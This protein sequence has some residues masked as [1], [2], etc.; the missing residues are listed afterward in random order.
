MEEHHTVTP[1]LEEEQV[2]HDGR[3]SGIGSSSTNTTKHPA[4]EQRSPRFRYCAPGV[5]SSQ[6][7]QS[8][9]VYWSLA[10]DSH[11]RHPYYVA[12]TEHQ[13]IE[14][15]EECGMRGV[16]VELLLKRFDGDGE[17]R[18][19]DI[20][21]EGEETD[22]SIS[23]DLDWSGKIERVIRVVAWNGDS[24]WHR[25]DGRNFL[26]VFKLDCARFQRILTHDDNKC[27]G[28][29]QEKESHDNLPCVLVTADMY[30]GMQ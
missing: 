8:D 26:K 15:H 25:V 21:D 19:V 22:C 1:V 29:R 27:S 3:Y 9:E 30:T 13:D 24:R 28:Q 12:D 2:G 5:G 18:A 6:D 4:S 14:S 16:D 23:E 20:R 7:Q 10:N 11:Q 17:I